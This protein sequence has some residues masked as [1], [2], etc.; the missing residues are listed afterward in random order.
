MPSIETHKIFGNDV[1]AK[2]NLTNIDKKIYTIFNQ[3]FDNFFYYKFFSLKKC[4]ETNYL[5]EKGHRQHSRDYLINIADNILKFKLNNSQCRAYLFGSINHYVLDSTCHPFIFYKTGAFKPEKKETYKYN[6]LHSKMELML[7]C[8]FYEQNNDKK[9]YKYKGYLDNFPKVKFSKKLNELIDKSI[10]DTFN[11]KNASKLYYKSYK[12]GRFIFKH[13]VYDPLGVKKIIYKFIDTLSPKKF[14]RC[15]YVSNY[16]KKIDEKYLNLDKKT[17]YHPVTKE[18]FDYSILDLY[19]IALKKSINY[20]N[21]FEKYLNKKITRKEL[22][23]KIDNIS[24]INGLNLDKKY[25]LKY[26]EF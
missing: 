25:V 14:R 8:Y 18:A 2:T 21:Y 1:L 6:S 7:D 12:E 9:F 16:I 17:W 10:F 24:Y 3:S 4:Y 15:K 26:F 22:Y 5:K 11:I 20:F 13:G 23:K 19:N